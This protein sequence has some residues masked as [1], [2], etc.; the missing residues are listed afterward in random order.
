MTA[1]EAV[2]LWFEKRWAHILVLLLVG[3]SIPLEIYELIQGISPLKLI[4]FVINIAVF[5]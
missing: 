4:V 1:I 5:W 3:I 2:G